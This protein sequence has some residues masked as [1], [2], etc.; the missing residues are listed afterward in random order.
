M[1]F[2]HYANLNSD[3]LSSLRSRFLTLT[4]CPL[5]FSVI[6]ESAKFIIVSALFYEQNVFFSRLGFKNR[7]IEVGRLLGA[8]YRTDEFLPFSFSSI[9]VKN[10]KILI[11][12][13]EQDFLAI[14]RNKFL[15]KNLCQIFQR[16]IE[17][18]LSQA[19][20]LTFIKLVINHL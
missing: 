4:C 3:R 16:V 10:E 5:P 6:Y 17:P 20:S 13:R 18:V 15:L 14:L 19:K 9:N 11:T 8:S 2:L 12:N 7:K 1:P